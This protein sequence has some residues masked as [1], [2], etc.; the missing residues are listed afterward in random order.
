MK[1]IAIFAVE[2][3]FVLSL[4]IILIVKL[5]GGFSMPFGLLTFRV[6]NLKNPII[7]LLGALFLRTIL[8][9]SFF[10]DSGWLNVLRRLGSN[11]Y[12]LSDRLLIILVVLLAVMGTVTLTNPLQRGLTGSYYNNEEWMGSPIMTTRDTSL[13]FKRINRMVPVVKDHF[14]IDWTGAIFVPVSGTYHFST[15]SEDGSEIYIDDQLVVDNRGIHEVRKRTGVISLEKGFYPIKIRHQFL[16]GEEGA[17]FKVY[18]K[19]PGHK[20]RQ[21]S[22]PFLF[23]ETPTEKA[24]LIGQ[25]LEILLIVCKIFLCIWGGSVALLG[26]SKY[27]LLP[28]PL[29]R[30][31]LLAFIFLIVFMGHFLWSKIY[32]AFDSGWNVYT[33]MSLMKERNT[34]LDEYRGLMKKDDHRI[35]RINGHSYNFF[36]VGTSI[37]S[38]PHILFL[39]N[40]SHE[41]LEIDLIYAITGR[42]ERFIAATIVASSSVLIYLIG[43]LF[44]NDQKYS[45]LLVFIF[46]F[47]TSAWSTASRALWQHGPT[48]LL[49]SASL[50]LL[51]LAKHK[52]KYEPWLIRFVGIPL[53]FSYVVRPTN[54][55]SILL[56][57]L[58][59]FI[60]HRKHFWSYCLWS[61][62]IAIPFFTFNLRVYHS[63]LSPYYLPNRLGTNPDFF[64]ALAGN[65]V[66]PSRGVFIFTPVLLFSLYGIFLKIRNKQMTLLDCS[67][68]IIMIL[69]WIAI[70]TFNPWC[71]GHS[72]GPRFFSD[73]IPYFIYFLIPVFTNIPK[74]QGG[75]KISVVLFLCCSIAVS[76]F[77]HYRGATN[78]DVYLW[79]VGPVSV[80]DKLWD[81]HD[82][83]FLEGLK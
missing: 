18:W 50:Y 15:I 67:L 68:L 6:H 39:D 82:L 25:F 75:R 31:G 37:L 48:M 33:S 26:I 63:I 13:G 66:S 19:R 80:E 20:R 11:R 46:A 55:I 69:H 30:L 23:V 45:L 3:I 7:S 47:C 38:L 49:L 72:Y 41:I 28:S 56:F 1:K 52:P 43:G 54:S 42:L 76:F 61:M 32:T 8:T 4:G 27:Y 21:L 73:M 16:E 5:T 14:S 65:L 78:W 83:Q 9:R 2:I 24:F 71:G 10:K 34:D 36:P 70:S 22:S 53:A 79:N 57:T 51:L 12:V 59:I 81:W 35:Q 40:L 58:F 74:L 44:L 77:I 62:F 64:E 29:K 17:V 60:R